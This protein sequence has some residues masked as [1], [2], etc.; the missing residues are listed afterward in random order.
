MKK[1]YEEKKKCQPNSYLSLF[2]FFSSRRK[3]KIRNFLVEKSN[4]AAHFRRLPILI[5]KLIIH[6]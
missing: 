6:T 5:F 3:K 4:A 1:K 2:N